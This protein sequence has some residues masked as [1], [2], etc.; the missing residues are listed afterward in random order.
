MKDEHQAVEYRIGIIANTAFSLINFRGPLIEAMGKRGMAVYA[1][2]PDY[3]ERT[4]AAVRSLG[5]TPMDFSLSRAGMNPF[6]DLVD[7]VKLVRQLRDLKLDASFCYFIKPVIY[8][9]LAAVLAGISRRVAMIEGVGYVFTEGEQFGLR[10]RVLRTLV[11]QLYKLAL[12]QTQRVFMLNPDDRKM[13]VELGMVEPEK[14][15]LL[16]GIGVDLDQFI[17]E[18][19]SA[20]PVSFILIARLLK[21][22]GIYDYIEAA[23]IVRRQHPRA[24]FVL[25]GSVD[26]NPGSI[27]LEEVKAWVAEGLIEW[28]GH[29]SDVKPWI[30]QSSVFV[31]PSYREGLPR[32]TQEVMAM[33]KPVITTDVPGCRETVEHGVNGFKVPVRDSAALAEVMLTFIRSPHLVEM[34][35]RASRRKAEQ[36]FDVHKIN[37]EILEA[38]GV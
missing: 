3:D 6:R 25:L 8:G 27:S 19:T 24:R 14:V 21:E 32:S 31:L 36:T 23:R 34:M 26:L 18:E 38:I 7:L 1:F 2:A 16:K 33:G 4:R 17:V 37:A 20:E 15:R 22:K 35:G 11:I 13:F 12:S 29:V 9:T 10:R 28:P 5:A 30:A